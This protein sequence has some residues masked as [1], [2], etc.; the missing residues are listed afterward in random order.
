MDFVVETIST[1]SFYYNLLLGIPKILEHHRK[2]GIRKRHLTRYLPVAHSEICA[3]EQK[4][5]I[6][7]PE[8]LRNFY[9]SSDGF[10]YQWHCTYE[11]NRVSVTGKIEIYP[12]NKLCQIVG[13]KTKVDPGVQLDG[14][15]YKLKLGNNM[16]LNSRFIPTIWLCTADMKF[17]YLADNFTMYFRMA[18]AHLGFPYWQL[19][20]TP[21]GV[22]EWTKVL[23]RL[24]YPKMLSSNKKIKTIE[25]L[26]KQR[27][28]KLQENY[29]DIPVNKLDANV[30]PGYPC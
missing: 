1:D 13:Y 29:P 30:L 6:L 21:N 15:R 24:L 20:Y 25:M 16:Y 14:V 9:T 22:P 2:F 3:W 11:M 28:K 18:V 10:F 19:L 23:M 7:L 26:K 17:Y 8:D 12:L 27:A 5:G 4:H